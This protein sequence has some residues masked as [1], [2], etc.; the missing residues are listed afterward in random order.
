MGRLSVVL[1]YI[2]YQ[3]TD[4]STSKNDVIFVET[5]RSFVGKEVG[6]GES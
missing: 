3:I 5:F 4:K 2:L 1:T 6:E